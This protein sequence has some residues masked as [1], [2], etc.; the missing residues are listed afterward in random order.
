MAMTFNIEEMKKIHPSI[1]DMIELKETVWIN[2]HKLA[3]ADAESTVALT[4]NDIYDA[5]DRLERFAPYLAKVFP[6]TAPARGIIESE[7]R[8]IPAMKDA[9]ERDQGSD[10]PG[11][12]YLK[13]LQMLLIAPTLLTNSA[14]AKQV[15]AWF[16]GPTIPQAIL[17]KVLAELLWTRTTIW[18]LL[19]SHP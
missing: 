16:H 17:L 9:L 7:L 15:T 12:L 11:K 13:A 6:E 2:P 10:I 19:L 5:R 8:E 3:E 4:I 18:F 14:M 1:G